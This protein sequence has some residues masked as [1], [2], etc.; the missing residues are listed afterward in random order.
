MASDYD[1][2]WWEP[3]PKPESIFLRN[4]KKTIGFFK[5]IFN[6]IFNIK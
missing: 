1:A 4:G 6:K 3:T 2:K 5:I